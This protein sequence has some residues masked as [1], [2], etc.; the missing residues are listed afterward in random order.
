MEKYTY[1]GNKEECMYAAKKKEIAYYM[2]TQ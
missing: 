1:P 2:E